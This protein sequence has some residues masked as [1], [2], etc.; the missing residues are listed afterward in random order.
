M[1]NV[2]TMSQLEELIENSK[3]NEAIAQK[4]F[5]IE[6]AIISSQT[7][8]EL[9]HRLLL[10]IKEKFELT[11]IHLLLASPPPLSYL[12]SNSAQPGWHDKNTTKLPASR[13]E[14]L[15]PNITPLLTNDLEQLEQLLPPSLA[16]VANS[17]ALTP[18][19]LEG[20]LFG[21]LVFTDA[22]PQRFSPS[23]GIYHLQQLGAKV[24][25]C[26]SNVLIR[27]QLEYM[28]NFDGLTGLGNR[29]LMEKTLKEELNRHQRYQVPFSVLFIDCNKFKQLNDTYGHDCGDKVLAYVATQLKDLIRDND[30]CFRYAG[31]EFVVALASQ[32]EKE[33]TLAAKRL[34]EYF[35]QNT[36]PY[37]NHQ[38]KITISCGVA[39]SDGK[40]S[41]EQLLNSADTQLY[42]HK[43]KKIDY[44]V[45]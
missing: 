20:K 37:E 21:S 28:A 24:S 14:A 44:E 2:V 43:N 38:L 15:H 39:T 23:L 34:V 6:T 41:I 26:L 4:L 33:A 29:R 31:D 1:D 10:L 45:N 13:L 22:D 3:A 27:E 12:I 19:M 5:D 9:L 30:R 11:N 32:G 25:L 16:K 35:E 40:K 8:K 17:A 42:L 18:L 36:M 7:S